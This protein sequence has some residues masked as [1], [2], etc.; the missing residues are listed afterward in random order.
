MCI[1]FLKI[2]RLVLYTMFGRQVSCLALAVASLLSGVNAQVEP[3]A[4]YD[5]G[6][7][8]TDAPVLLRIANGGAGQSGL[9]KGMQ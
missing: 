8:S 2:S 4:I 7:N 1:S 6:L 9:I 5:G 3:Q